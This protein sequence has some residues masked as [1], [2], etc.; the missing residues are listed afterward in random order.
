MLS[1]MVTLSL[2]MPQ[3]AVARCK[4]RT[5]LTMSV[6]RVVLQRSLRRSRQLFRVISLV[7]PRPDVG[8]GERFDDASGA[9]GLDVV[10]GIRRGR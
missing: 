1:L 2:S 6:M 9:G 4:A 7:C 5:A 10:D 8:L 3:A